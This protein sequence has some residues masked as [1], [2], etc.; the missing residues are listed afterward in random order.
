MGMSGRETYDEICHAQSKI[1]G[2]IPED[3]FFDVEI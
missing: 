3:K 1:L 2:M